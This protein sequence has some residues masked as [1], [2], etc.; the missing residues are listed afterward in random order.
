MKT[1]EELEALPWTPDDDTTSFV[2]KACFS[3]G[4]NL[5]G[6]EMVVRQ[7]ANAYNW[8]I[9]LA[10]KGGWYEVNGYNCATVE[11]AKRM[12]ILTM[13]SLLTSIQEVKPDAN[14]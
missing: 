1:L 8:Y 11:K 12:A 6:S 3:L 2:L 5:N 14:D 10:T 9:F 13:H 7:Y 4:E